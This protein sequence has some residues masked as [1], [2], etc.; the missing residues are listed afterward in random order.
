M[1]EECTEQFEISRE[2]DRVCTENVMITICKVRRYNTKLLAEA[3]ICK[4]IK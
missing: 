3:K 1:K 2:T 4:G